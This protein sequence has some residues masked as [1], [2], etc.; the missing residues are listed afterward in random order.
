[1]PSLIKLYADAQQRF[2]SQI[3]NNKK[4]KWEKSFNSMK[5]ALHQCLLKLNFE[6]AVQQY[7]KIYAVM[8]D[9][10]PENDILVAG[11][12]TE[13]VVESGWLLCNRKTDA[14]DNS[15]L[16]SVLICISTAVMHYNCINIICADHLF[17]MKLF[18][19]SQ[20]YY[21]ATYEM[22]LNFLENLQSLNITHSID[23]SNFGNEIRRL[24]LRI[25]SLSKI[26]NKANEVT[27]LLSQYDIMSSRHLYHENE[28]VR[29]ERLREYY[30]LQKWKN[31]I[32]IKSLAPI[33]RIEK[34]FNIDALSEI[35]ACLERQKNNETS[36]EILHEIYLRQNR[37]LEHMS[38]INEINDLITESIFSEVISQAT[39][40][41][42]L[43]ENEIYQ[44]TT[45]NEISLSLWNTLI[46][47]AL[48][49]D[50]A[51]IAHDVTQL[52]ESTNS[53][54]DTSTIN[55]SIDD[56]SETTRNADVYPTDLLENIPYLSKVMPCCAQDKY[57]EFI[58]YFSTILEEYNYDAFLFGSA[59]YKKNPNDLDIFL[60]IQDMKTVNALMGELILNQSGIILANYS[61]VNRRVI[62][63]TFHGIS[64]DFILSSET[65]LEH[66][67][68]LDF[69]IGALYFDLRRKVMFL[70]NDRA[71][72]H[73]Q[74]KQLHTISD[75]RQMFEHDPSVILRAVRIMASENFTLSENCLL[76]IKE[77]FIIENVFVKMNPD[78]LY[79]EMVKLFF[80]GHAVRV[81]DIL[82]KEL[83]IFQYIFSRLNELSQ[84]MYS[85]TLSM[86][87]CVADMSDDYSQNSNQYLYPPSPSLFYYAVHWFIFVK[88]NGAQSSYPNIN[89]AYGLTPNL[90]EEV[91]YNNKKDLHALEFYHHF[92]PKYVTFKEHYSQSRNSFWSNKIQINQLCYQDL[93]NDFHYLK[94]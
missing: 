36:Q 67:R 20:P 41:V 26:K 21:Q 65:I 93:S 45:T 46:S 18:S 85:L 23:I 32:K 22:L 94:F 79:Y 91:D 87:E 1:M 57:S 25:A 80:S 15:I 50:L 64:I 58:A 66:S 13:L 35:N 2:V 68:R 16:Q 6:S 27:E 14:S 59:N 71:F 24:I 70:P 34:I 8:K 38:S 44:E 69:T 78:K 72:Q 51:F 88:N 12:V 84:S 5:D 29:L 62:K 47:E 11:T 7:Y 9:Y 28:Q 30:G 92:L 3:N 39:L 90:N 89:L 49:E 31:N 10:P 53:V 43:N 17:E 75:A 55:T 33:D 77:V 54:C 37:I 60:N 48:Q 86:V 56:I 61:K 42:A 52:V 4:T 19:E 63:M 82:V 74:I 76:A 81:F 73:I 40:D 83:D